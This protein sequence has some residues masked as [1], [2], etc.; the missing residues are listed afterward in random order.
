MGRGGTGV[1][2]GFKEESCKVLKLE[3]SLEVVVFLR[4][5]N[6]LLFIVLG[7]LFVTVAWGQSD[8]PYT[9]PPVT[10]DYSGDSDSTSDSVVNFTPEDEAVY[11]KVIMFHSSGS[12]T[13]RIEIWDPSGEL[14]FYEDFGVGDAS[15][16][17]GSFGDYQI[18][19][20]MPIKDSPAA[21]MPGTWDV[22]VYFQTGS[23]VAGPDSYTIK[24]K[25]LEFYI[26][27]RD[28]GRREIFVDRASYDPV[29]SPGEVVNVNVELSWVFDTAT[30]ANAQIIDTR[31]GAVV[32]EKADTLSGEGSKTVSF[33]F[34][35]PEEH[36]SY[37]YVVEVP[38][39]LN[40]EWYL[41]PEADYSV[42]FTV[43]E[44]GDE[45]VGNTGRDETDSGDGVGD[46]G[47]GDIIQQI[48]GYPVASILTAL[49]L[50]YSVRCRSDL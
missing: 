1:H 38:Y 44:S 16:W 40:G 33:S 29:Y 27:Q 31:S 7:S 17:G 6:I 36:G 23:G 47:V 34:S 43:E 10:Y 20:R 35:A 21:D 26:S 3:N 18:E 9:N 48:P 37:T 2:Q 50:V 12:E 30:D 24:H 45:D 4:S 19:S 8:T 49:A 15:G 32:K 14:E 39:L 41:D 11:I 28:L 22:I 25:K 13:H 42:Q 46:G 5:T